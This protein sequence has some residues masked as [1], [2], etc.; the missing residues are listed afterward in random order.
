MCHSDDKDVQK[1]R[2]KEEEGNRKSLERWW[3]F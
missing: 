1:V 2:E 3:F